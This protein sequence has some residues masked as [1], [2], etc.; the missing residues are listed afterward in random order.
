MVDGGEAAPM[1]RLV[2]IMGGE[3]SAEVL[4][5]YR[6][7]GGVA[8]REF[9]RAASRTGQA[10]RDPNAA[11]APRARAGQLLCA[12][13]AFVLQILGESLF[14]T[15]YPSDLGR[16]GLVS[17]PVAGQ[18][19]AFLSQVEPWVARAR[20]AAMEPGYR[21]Q[22]ELDLPAELPLWAR[23]ERCT[24]AWL[25]AM[26]S[27]ARKIRVHA[28]AAVANA[29]AAAGSGGALDGGHT[30]RL[31]M[32]LVKASTAAERA[33]RLLA[34]EP[35]RAVHEVIEEQV[36]RA[37]A[38]YYRVGQL[39]AMPALPDGRLDRVLGAGGPL[40]LDA[41]DIWYLTD[42]RARDRWR[43]DPRARR[44]VAAL[45]EADP[46]PGA[47]VRIQAEI[48]VALRAGAISEATGLSGQRLGHYFRCP[49]PAVYEVRR[50]VVLGDVPLRPVQQF[51]YDVSASEGGSFTRRIRVGTFIPAD[52]A[53]YGDLQPTS[54]TIKTF[55]IAQAGTWTRPMP[56]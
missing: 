2:S 11:A 15:G 47:T 33:E 55:Q 35:D 5:A 41:I 43:T 29:E 44:S 34:A 24:A 45:W 30:G 9:E 16:T 46:E 13:N 28:E 6:R 22:E 25:R 1:T 51:T 17:A 7:T 38:A 56:N 21:V 48:E 52:E 27:A 53:D 10:A 40:D 20:R 37:L 4:E 19:L 49:W 54:T 39:A 31:A 36:H 32:W 42:S 14:D 3:V 18:V 50:R 8:Y 23:A 12:W 26:A